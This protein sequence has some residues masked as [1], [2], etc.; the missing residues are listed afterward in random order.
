MPTISVF[1]GIFIR[2]YLNDHAPPHFHAVYG[3]QEAQIAI[4]TGEI[5]HGKL[6]RSARR[7]VKEW[8]ELN[9]E[10]LLQNWQRAQEHQALKGIDGLDAAEGN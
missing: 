4:A 5:M 6:P 7:L 1:Y 2:M 3:D 8:T 9:R 10:Q